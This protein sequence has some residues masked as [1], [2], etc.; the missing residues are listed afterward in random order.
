MLLG[1]GVALAVLAAVAAAGSYEY[2]YALYDF[3]TDPGDGW[4]LMSVADFVAHRAEFV[5]FYNE[6]DGLAPVKLFR[7][8]NCCFAVKGG[9]KLT[10]TGTPYGYQFPAAQSG[11]IR[12]NP[13]DGFSEAR[14]KFYKVDKLAATAV[15]G[16]KAACATSHNPAVW[17]RRM[18]RPAVEFGM[19][20][21][22]V[23]PGEGW[24][25]ADIDMINTHKAVFIKQYNERGLTRIKNFV[26]GNCCMAVKGGTKLIISGTPYGFQFPLDVASGA[27]HCSL[28]EGYA[29][30]AYRFYKVPQ[31]ADAQTFTTKAACVTN[32]NPGVYVRITETK[33]EQESGGQPAEGAVLFGMYDYSMDPGDG[34]HA[35]TSAQLNEHKAVFVKHYN[36]NKGLN[37][38]KNFQSGNCCFALKGGNKLIIS[39]TPY[40]Y[41]FPSNAGGDIRCNPSAGYTEGPYMFYRTSALTMEMS[42]SD[43]AACATSHNPG[44]FIKIVAQQTKLEFGMYDFEK[45]PAGGW[46]LLTA[47]ELEANKKE[48]I[49]RYNEDGGIPPVASFQSGNCCFATKGGEHLIISDT[50]YGYQFPAAQGAADIRC[51]PTAGYS[52]KFYT[53]FRVVELSETIM[54]S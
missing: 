30:D 43:R 42:F 16:S 44:L 29:G 35:A 34:W 11:G 52:E 32:H 18:A 22:S 27:V 28:K 19:F 7:T 12:C 54:Q 20:D 25:L 50:P 1:R 4:Q 5:R 8:G 17:M 39:G 26:S 41:Q 10:I 51:N 48:F 45:Q 14:Y 21:F 37:V 53:F 36:A 6:R 38:I 13:P 24:Q 31:L 3:Q 46:Q 49:A 40:G 23:A 15:F 9:L 47:A 2:E 33:E